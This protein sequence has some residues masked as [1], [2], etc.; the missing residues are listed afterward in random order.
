MSRID[1]R[2]FSRYA[3]LAFLSGVSVIVSACG[4]SSYSS[5]SN[6]TT[7]TPEP[8]GPGDDVGQISANHGHRAVITA[9]QLMAGGALML[10]IRG[11]ADHT[12][13]VSLSAQDVG[14][15]R[16]GATV[17][18]LSTTGQSTTLPAHAHTVTFNPGSSTPP[19]PGY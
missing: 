3:S 16:A 4:G 18:T 11:A 10:D 6:P 9:A 2:E 1:R 7:P 13:T 17:A 12:H 14:D 5:P 19:S 8:A 15:V